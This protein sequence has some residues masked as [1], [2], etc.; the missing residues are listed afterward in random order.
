M[1]SLEIK[2]TG[3]PWMEGKRDFGQIIILENKTSYTTP[4]CEAVENSRASWIKGTLTTP[5]ERLW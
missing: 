4:Q 3:S 5:G 2:S 1:G